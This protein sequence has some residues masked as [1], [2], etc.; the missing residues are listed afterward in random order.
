MVVSR[1]SV[2]ATL[3]AAGALGM[4]FRAA[5][6]QSFK[7]RQYHPQPVTS[8]LHIYLTKLWDA[9]RA[10]TN[11]RLDV[12]VHAQ[13]NGVPIADPDILKQIQSGELEFFVLNGNI[14]SQVHPVA[15]IQGIPF[16]FTTSEQVTSLTDGE[17]GALMRRE[18][19]GGGV[20]LIPFG[21][22][23]NG[24]KHITA[25]AKPIRDA[26]DLEG[27]R[28]R[29]PGGK[30]FVEFYKALGAEPK[31]IGFNKLYQALAERQVD[32]Q[33]NPLVIAEE[34]KLYEVCRYLSL[35]NHQWAGYNMIANNAYWQSLPAD[36][37]D[38]V[39]RNAKIYVAQQRAFVRA[40]NARLEKTLRDRGMI[41][42]A[43]DIDSFRKRLIDA[44][45][46]HV[47]RQSIG[48]KA[49][50]LMEAEVGKVG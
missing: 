12:T 49:W 43:V 44:H 32:G 41:V 46:Y 2:V 13:N 30:L 38:S 3:A 45:F 37:Q 21:G 36:I 50:A 33:E 42:N 25:V 23:E 20:Y 4:L 35:T 47:W 48:D 34:N 10:E 11:G 27:F 8:H 7:A 6:A 22:M 9:V 15:D 18:L 28:M 29:T 31:I 24:F 26:A 39:V 1:R 5:R 16:A 40:A 17:L 19:A 14:L